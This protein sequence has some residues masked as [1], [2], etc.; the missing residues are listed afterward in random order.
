MSISTGCVCVMH[1]PACVSR[2]LDV[3]RHS[4]PVSDGTTGGGIE[5]AGAGPDPAL[6][7]HEAADRFPRAP[8]QTCRHMLLLL[9]GSYAR[10]TDQCG[11]H[12]HVHT[13]T[14]QHALTC[15]VHLSV[16]P[17]TLCTFAPFSLMGEEMREKFWEVHL[18]ALMNMG[19]F[20]NSSVDTQTVWTTCLIPH[21]HIHTT[22][23]TCEQTFQH[24]GHN[25]A[26][27]TYMHTHDPENDEL[28]CKQLWVS[29]AYTH[30]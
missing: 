12:R 15:L 10:G 9:G 16:L 20:L 3:L 25:Y 13:Y 26:R 6:V 5:S 24:V 28:N 19:H 7:Y 18:H 8:Q 23:K 29:Q 27:G 2:W 22:Q 21:T 14:L 1:L 17:L 30:T 4:L 11:R